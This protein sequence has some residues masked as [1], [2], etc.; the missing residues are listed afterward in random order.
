[1]LP[2]C[3]TSSTFQRHAIVDLHVVVAGQVAAAIVTGSRRGRRLPKG[4]SWRVAYANRRG[5]NVP[6]VVKR[7]LLAGDGSGAMD[8]RLMLLCVEELL[9]RLALLR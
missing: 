2:A 5:A 1:M 8:L 3:A 9:L 7:L 6:E 4:A